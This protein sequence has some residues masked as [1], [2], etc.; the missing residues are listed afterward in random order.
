[1]S[2]SVHVMLGYSPDVKMWLC[3]LSAG[4]SVQSF[5]TKSFPLPFFDGSLHPFIR[6]SYFT[7]WWIHHFHTC[8]MSPDRFVYLQLVYVWLRWFPPVCMREGITFTTSSHVYLLHYLGIPLFWVLIWGY[9]PHFHYLCLQYNTQTDKINIFL[10]VSGFVSQP[11]PQRS[12]Y[13]MIWYLSQSC[14]QNTN[15][16]SNAHINTNNKVCDLLRGNLINLQF[17]ERKKSEK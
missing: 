15:T 10:S 12:K 6:A 13:D 17:V 3:S 7:G 5:Q 16:N 11:Q 8:C 14:L 1:M 4:P 2:F 9:V